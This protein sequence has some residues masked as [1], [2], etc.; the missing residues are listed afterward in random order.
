[1]AYES[2]ILGV[3]F[4]IGIFAVKSGLGISYVVDGQKQKRAKAGVFLLFAMTYGLVFAAA[5]AALTRIDPVRHL[6]AIDAFV[7]SGMMVHLLLAGLL[8]VWGVLLLKGGGGNGKKSRAWLLLAVPCP[9]CATVIFFSAAFLC[10]LF[11]EVPNVAVLLLY[12]AFVSINLVTLVM[13]ALYR[14][15]RAGAAESF[16]GGAMLLMALYFFVS[17]TVMPQFADVE[18]IYRLAL[19][20]GETP[21]QKAVHL[22]PFS[23][24]AASAFACGYGF[25]SK[26][27]RSLT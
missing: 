11:P 5:A 6:A 4:S 22:L 8:M 17:V 19:Y 20:Q 3:L 2:L 24:L 1:M 7:R 14:N 25:M 23:L 13:A 15:R 10:A 16:L 12:L 18:K 9:V 21:P 27:M 26:K